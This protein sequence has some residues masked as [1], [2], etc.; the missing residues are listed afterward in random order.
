MN[1]ALAK[2]A[3]DASKAPGLDIEQWVEAGLMWLVTRAELEPERQNIER[4]MAV[5]LEESEKVEAIVPLMQWDTSKLLS[6]FQDSPVMAQ[7]GLPAR[8][9]L[10]HKDVRQHLIPFL[11]FERKCLKW[12]AGSAVCKVFSEVGLE[13]SAIIRGSS[14]PAAQGQAGDPPARPSSLGKRKAASEPPAP[15]ARCLSSTPA[16]ISAATAQKLI[17]FLAKQLK[18]MQ[19]AVYAMPGTAGAVPHIFELPPEE[20]EPDDEVVRSLLSALSGSNLTGLA[21][22]SCQAAACLLE[23]FPVGA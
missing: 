19:D 22:I 7:L 23:G 1:R 6:H 20:R 11:D 18:F 9:L 15:P 17:N 10:S 14:R 8:E 12:Y 3:L 2:E 4:A 21:T 16:A 13:C 5:S